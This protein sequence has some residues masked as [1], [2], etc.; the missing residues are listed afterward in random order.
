MMIGNSK[1]S[2]SMNLI[3]QIVSQWRGLKVGYLAWG[4]GF[5]RDAKLCITIKAK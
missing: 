2:T 5:D 4:N 1:V 3:H